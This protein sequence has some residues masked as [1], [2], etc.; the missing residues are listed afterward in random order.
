MWIDKVSGLGVHKGVQ[1]YGVQR[2]GVEGFGD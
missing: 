2:Y 1:G